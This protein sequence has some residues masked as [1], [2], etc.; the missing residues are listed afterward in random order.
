MAQDAGSVSWLRSPVL[1]SF[2]GRPAFCFHPL[3]TIEPLERVFLSHEESPRILGLGS[4]AGSWR[5]VTCWPTLLGPVPAAGDGDMQ[6]SWAT[7]GVRW[8]PEGN[9]VRALLVKAAGSSSKDYF[10]YY[11]TNEEIICAF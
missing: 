2:L 8:V 7:R 11:F 5:T 1:P 6:V 4:K 3:L 9:Q 10:H